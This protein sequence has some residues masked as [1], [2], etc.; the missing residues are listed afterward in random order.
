[1][2]EENK[3]SVREEIAKDRN[4]IVVDG[5]LGEP[6][7]A[8][9][10][11]KEVEIIYEDMDGHPKKCRAIYNYVAFSRSYFRATTGPAKGNRMCGVIAYRPIR[12]DD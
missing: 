1:M 10:W 6:V 8:L 11:D 9:V 7:S 2:T 4:W 5:I 12:E 3:R